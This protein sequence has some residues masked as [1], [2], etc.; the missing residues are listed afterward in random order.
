M[1]KKLA[2][3]IIGVSLIALFGACSSDKS[4]DIDD[5]S[6]TKQPQEDIPV[7]SKP[8]DTTT[9]NDFDLVFVYKDPGKSIAFNYPDIQV[10]EKGFARV[11]RRAEKYVIVF[12]RSS[13]DQSLP[14]NEIN[15]SLMT[16]FKSATSSHFS[17]GKAKN[18]VVESSNEQTINGVK[19]LKQQG[20]ILS[21][22]D[23][24]HTQN[25][26]MI[27]Y[28]FEKDGVVCQMIGTVTN[29][30]QEQEYIDEVTKRVDSMVQTLR[31]DR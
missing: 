11:F 18:F 6:Q 2:L 29:A 30:E 19:M 8:K 24:G 4:T 25:C 31:D 12:N 20:Y 14:L 3:L 5:I 13:N 7:T 16:S 28:T 22:D 15:D 27:G 21:D 23:A 9:N 10:I 1:K 26:F 17:V